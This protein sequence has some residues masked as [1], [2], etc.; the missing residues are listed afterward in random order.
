MRWCSP[1]STGPM[2]AKPGLFSG[3]VKKFGRSGLIDRMD[4]SDSF[5]YVAAAI[6]VLMVLCIGWKAYE[7]VWELRRGVSPSVEVRP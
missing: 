1:R 3:A 6:A 4:K 7:R 2:N 5:V